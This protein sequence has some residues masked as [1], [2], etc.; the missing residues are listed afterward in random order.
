MIA[1]M[2]IAAALAGLPQG[3]ACAF[4]DERG[5]IGYAINA[6]PAFEAA[7][8]SWYINDEKIAHAGGSYAKYGLPR[9]LAPEEIEAVHDKDGVPLFV[10]ACNYVDKPEIIYVMV[11]SADCSFQ[12]YA[13]E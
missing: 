13:R 5:T 6:T 3:K 7:G 1:T 9:Q 2:L 11:R 8:K 4:H 12:P 10:A